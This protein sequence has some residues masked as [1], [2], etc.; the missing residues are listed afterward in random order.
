[1]QTLEKFSFASFDA[2]AH[3]CERHQ[4]IIPFNL[5]QLPIRN[6]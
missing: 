6:K 1:M 2:F 5:I 3:V 4:I